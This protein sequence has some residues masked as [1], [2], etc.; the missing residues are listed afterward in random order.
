[1]TGN[2]AGL[3][4]FAAVLVLIFAGVPVAV[5]MAVVGTAGLA[6]LSQ[7][8]TVAFVLGSVPY[9]S[10]TPYTLSVVPLFILMGVLAARGGL[11][12]E[13]YQAVNALI[14]H[15][16][17]GL[18]MATVGACA[19]FGGICGSSLA[20]AA[21]MCR[22]ALPEMRAN[23]YDDRLACAV[24]AAGGTLGILIPPSIILSIYGL[25]TETSIGKLFIAALLPGALATALYMG[26]VRWVVTF[27]PDDA[28]PGPRLDW[29]ARLAALVQVWP[30]ALLFLVVIGGI[31]LGWFS[32][33][34]GAAVGCIGALI[35]G[36]LR[37][38]LDRAAI[39]ETIVET[40]NTTGMVYLILI[41]AM[42]FNAFLEMSGMPQ[43]LVG[44]VRDWG[45]SPLQVVVILV[46]FY[47]IL[48]CFMDALSMVLL[49][50]P[51]VFPLIQALAIDPIWFGILIVTVVEIGLITPPVGMNLFVIQAVGRVP[52]ETV[53]R[54]I[55]PFIVAD[56]IRVALLIA[57][58]AI[59]L[60]LTRFM[61]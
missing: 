12:R 15:W 2:A 45:A 36:L 1:M 53:I 4:G 56:F 20:T 18:A 33:T 58:P 40:A 42:V 44:L 10:I 48:G 46:V 28:P 26:A 50:I 47:V 43:W 25:L 51:V 21:T 34:E 57:F 49:T 61:D 8:S 59:T 35:A 32:P 22:V 6:I 37:R 31:Y 41:G 29:R 39:R 24:I 54:G 30:V 19:A 5:S 23:N 55:V 52:Q 13:L 3:V 14:G 16:R 60:Y 17:G 38:Q 7:W 11:S 9:D 27:R